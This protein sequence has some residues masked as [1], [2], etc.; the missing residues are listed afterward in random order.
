MNHFIENNLIINIQ[1]SLDLAPPVSYTFNTKVAQDILKQYKERF[2]K[3]F[4]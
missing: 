2:M 4:D 3:I 1:L